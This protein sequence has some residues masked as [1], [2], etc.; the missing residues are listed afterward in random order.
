MR[1]CCRPH[2]VGVIIKVE[3]DSYRVLDQDGS[4]KNIRAQEITQK[5]D[6]KKAVS[7]DANQNT[8]QVGDIIEVI[9]GEHQVRLPFLDG[10]SR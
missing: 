1:D 3:K 2:T 8:I 5:R 10:I 6:S 9:G 4:I 7:L